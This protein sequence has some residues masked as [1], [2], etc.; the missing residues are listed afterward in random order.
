MTVSWLEATA[1]AGLP[2]ETVAV[3]VDATVPEL[4][5]T[6][7]LFCVNPALQLSRMDEKSMDSSSW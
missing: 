5:T 4:D 3:T 1:D 7:G 2:A 6:K